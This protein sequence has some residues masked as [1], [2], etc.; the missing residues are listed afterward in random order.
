MSQNVNLYEQVANRIV[1]LIEQGVFKT[2]ERIP[3]VR[4]LQQQL[5]VSQ[6]TVLQA[7]L[8]LENQGLIESR[9]QSGYYVKARLQKL[10]PTPK[11]SSPTPAATKV[12]MNEL[13][14][15]LLA[16]SQDPCVIPLGSVIPGAELFPTLKLNRALI[17]VIRRL[18]K[19][20]NTYEALAGNEDLRYQLA[21]R[22]LDWSSGI[23][24]EEIVTTAGCMEAM[25]LCLRAV[26]QPGDTIAIESPTYYGILQMIESLNLNILEVPTHP[27][28][29]VSLES[30]EVVL[31]KKHVKACLFTLNFNNPLGSCLPD[32]HKKQ[33]VEMLAHHEIPLIENDIQGDLY[34]DHTRPRSA[35]AFDQ[36]GLVLLCSSFSKTLAA[37]YRVGWCVPGRYQAQVEYLKFITN[38]P[39]STLAQAT[40]AEFLQR[41]SYD[42]HLRRTRK[43]LSDQVLQVT[44]TIYEHFPPGTR[45]IDP[46]GGLFLWVELPKTVNSLELQ[47]QSLTERISIA[48]GPIF[49]SKDTYQN[50]IRLNCGHPWSSILKQGLITLGCLVTKMD[51]AL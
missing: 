6:S 47:R 5:G 28:N 9:P 16:A 18:G 10:P 34:F 20:V 36:K 45:V 21:K 50:F 30:L 4:N 24:S 25:N 51:H 37:G 32:K 40:I 42:Q 8:L 15:S 49:S 31:K 35:K 38:M 26:A 12:S 48:P 19:Q 11:T 43:T 44:Q 46:T 13:A 2:E 17:K 39:T 41:G 33:L 14:I 7:Y 29:G 22:S 27:R 3:S 23:L 1:R